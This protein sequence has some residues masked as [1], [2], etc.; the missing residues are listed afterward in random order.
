MYLFKLEFCLEVC[1]GVGLLDHKV[2]Q[3]LVFWGT[4]ILLSI[5]AEPIYIST[6]SI[7]GFLFLHTLFSIYYLDFLMMAVLTGVRYLIVVLTSSSRIIIDIEYFSCVCR[8]SVELDSCIY[9]YVNLIYMYVCVCVWRRQWHPTPVLLPG[10]SHGRRSLVGC[11]P[12]GC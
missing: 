12:W 7:G 11:S 2:L 9:V 8:P 10:K 6:N 5:V 4:S 3:F 1:L